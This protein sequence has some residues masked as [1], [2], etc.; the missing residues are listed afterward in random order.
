MFT[1]LTDD[2]QSHF[3]LQLSGVRLEMEMR[4]E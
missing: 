1:E 2:V 3:Q 4:F